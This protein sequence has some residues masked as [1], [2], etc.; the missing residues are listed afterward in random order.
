MFCS[1]IGRLSYGMSHVSGHQ[2][3][4]VA[5]PGAL[6]MMVLEMGTKGDL[7][8]PR[9]RQLSGVDVSSLRLL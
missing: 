4:M 6:V 7:D 2:R 9:G 5:A 1:I 8:A 3:I